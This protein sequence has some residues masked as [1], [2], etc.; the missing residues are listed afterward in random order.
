MTF[1]INDVRKSLESR[2]ELC[3]ARLKKWREKFDDDPARAF[4][5]GLGEVQDASRLKVARLLLNGLNCRADDGVADESI[6][7]D[8]VCRARGSA[9]SVAR[10]PERTTSPV[11][12]LVHE[13]I[14]AAWAEFVDDWKY[15]VEEK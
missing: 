5:W 13:Y 12:K 3:T 2:I 8:L 15:Y 11:S 6:L 14:G 7:A 4:E 9:M 1:E 10:W